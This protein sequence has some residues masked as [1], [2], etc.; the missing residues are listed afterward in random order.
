MA[1]CF[2]WDQT[3]SGVWGCRATTNNCN[4]QDDK[5]PFFKTPEQFRQGRID[6]LKRIAKLPEWQQRAISDTHYKGEM[7]WRMYADAPEA[8]EAGD[9]LDAQISAMVGQIDA[10]LSSGEIAGVM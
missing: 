3:P 5:C 1:Y 6:A 7:P 8:P 2:A 9:S 4:G 10:G